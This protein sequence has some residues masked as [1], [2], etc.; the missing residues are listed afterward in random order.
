MT[1]HIKSQELV[2]RWQPRLYFYVPS[3]DPR[4]FQSAMFEIDSNGDSQPDMGYYTDRWGG[5]PSRWSPKS[6]YMGRGRAARCERGLEFKIPGSALG[7]LERPQVRMTRLNG[8][9]QDARW[10]GF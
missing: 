8:E 3:E 2:N 7:P 1:N 10:E 9:K 6:I 4:K 5:T